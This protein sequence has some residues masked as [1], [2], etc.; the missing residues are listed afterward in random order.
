MKDPRK[1]FEKGIAVYVNST[2]WDE[3]KKAI[4]IEDETHASEL[5]CILSGKTQRNNASGITGVHRDSR[6]GQWRAQIQFKHKL[7]YLGRFDKISDAIDARRKAE[8]L[9]FKPIVEKF[10]SGKEDAKREAALL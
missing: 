5:A 7:L 2:P 6:R 3:R 8:E 10:L 4:G 9:Y 1:Y